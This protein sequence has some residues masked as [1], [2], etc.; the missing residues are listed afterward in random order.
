[1]SR[2]SLKDSL[3]C[4]YSVINENVLD[5]KSSVIN[6][7]SDIDR[8]FT[9]GLGINISKVFDEDDFNKIVELF[10]FLSNMSIDLL[11]RLMKLV[12]VI[13]NISA[14]LHLC[15]SVTIDEDIENYLT[16]I[17]APTYP[18]S[19]DRELTTYGQAYVLC[20]VS[21]K[22]NLWPFL[23]SYFKC[24]NFGEICIMGGKGMNEFQVAEQHKMQTYCGIGK[25][26]YPDN[27]KS[28]DWQFMNDL[29]KKHMTKIVFQLEKECLHTTQPSSYSW[30]LSK[31]L[32][33][34]R[35]FSKNPDAID[36]IIFLRNCWFHGT[37]LNDEIIY[38]RTNRKLN[39]KFIFDSFFRIKKCLLKTES[40][41]SVLKELNKFASSSINFY[42]LRL[43]EVSYKIL[44]NRLL[45]EDKLDSRLDNLDS[46]YTRFL[47]TNKDFYELCGKLIEPDDL[48][49]NVS[50]SKFLDNMPRKTVC[51]NLQI[52][53]FH[54]QNGFEIGN[55]HTDKQDITLALVRLN[56]NFQNKVNG[57]YLEDYILENEEKFGSR[58][59]TFFVQKEV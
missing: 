44:D 52:I 39:Y 46:A 20:F 18:I 35:V 27:K 26:I 32:K 17:V 56:K 28:I 45:T 10:P 11:N 50:G 1:M 55:Y 14:H 7:C 30:A 51:H 23:T 49:F 22:Y 33:E 19:I 9:L 34:S 42:C 15:L 54:S 53:R 41:K 47:Q 16:S 5:I 24:C 31:S 3:F 8:Y 4:A 25:P 40:F 38:N 36:L 12:L 6:L 59:S 29:F 48:S 43:V 21:Q 2:I 37:N 57:I 58:I 13:R